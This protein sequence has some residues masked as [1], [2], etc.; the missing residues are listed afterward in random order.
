M[1]KRYLLIITML[2]LLVFFT[3]KIIFS[4]VSDKKIAV[5]PKDPGIEGATELPK[6]WYD[7]L[8]FKDKSFIFEFI[9]TMGYS[10]E[11]GADI[12]E[13]IDTAR[14]IKDGDDLSWYNEWLSTAERIFKFAQNMEKD[15]DPV[16]AKEAYLR[17]SNYYRT[18][19]FYMHSKSDLPKALL[20][21]KKSKDSF[22]KAVSLAKN[23]EI[24]NI[25]Y[26]DTLLPGYFIKTKNPTEKKPPLLIVHTGFDGTAEE[27]FFEVGSAA[28][29]RGYNCLVF[30][31][32]GQ[33]QVIREQ[34]ISFRYDWEKVVT[35]VIDY[36]ISRPDVDKEKLA[37]MGISMGG[38]L[39]PRAAAFE[40]RIKAC[41]ANGGIYDFSA[42]FYKNMPPE[43]I[44]LLKQDPGEFNAQMQ[45]AMKS[46][47]QTRW[48]FN[49]GMYTFNARSP[50]EFASE[51]TKY[52]LKDAVKKIKCDMLIIDSEDDMS[53]KG[54]AKKL[55]D[56]LNC[57][58]DYLL[59]T[60]SQT[61][62]AHCQMGAS[63]ISNEVIFNWLDKVFSDPFS[64]EVQARLEQAVEKNLAECQDIKNIPGAVVGIWVPGK[65]SW[66]KTFGVSDLA[67]GNK[68]GLNNKF[69]IGSNTKTFVVTVL[70]QLT[71]EGRASLDDT[72]DKFNF[73][74]NIPDENKI[75]IR[76]L[77]NMTSGIPEIGDNEE[78]CEIFYVKNPLKK[79]LPTEI[80]KSALVNKPT[81]PPGEG[82]YYS[83][84][85]YILLGM[86]IEKITGNKLEDEIRERI[87]KPMNLANT[88]FPVDYP[89][90]PS[91]YAHGYELD[92]NKKWQ[93]V[94]IYSPSMLWAAGAMISDAE[95]MKA[96]V[97][98]YTT[99]TTNSK[100]TQKER[101]IW[102]DTHKGKNLGFG[103][104]IGNTNGWLGYTGGT[105]GYNT[106]AYYLPSS[107]AT[108]IVFVNTTDYSKDGVSVANK[109]VH[110]I[111]QILFPDQVAW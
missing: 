91:P 106:A 61:A 42:T 108:V 78:M 5:T 70:L 49:N 41:I 110:D 33:G 43:I 96:W 51:I 105:R 103:L 98:A 38:Y 74:I 21:W 102:V 16:S 20:S 63:A 76:Q 48:Y 60:R 25:P 4:E 57:P 9:R 27:L 14:R 101:L 69:R 64:K 50:A 71:D 89:G 52:N 72:L 3:Q 109:I 15:A 53:L 80:V 35:P 104:G 12:G 62:Q 22:L 28:A 79:W 83:N 2:A 45:E 10:Y 32:P 65:G 39:A 19:G 17:A 46:S 93:D 40:H 107:D 100:A 90:M 34:K 66:E 55:Y 56:E 58:K 8:I 94:T 29:R 73:G 88:S 36:A 84:T 54:E 87:L 59:F 31:G 92:D 30:E 6:N 82:W 13:C 37:L 11:G 26:Q 95:D 18:A 81:F 99:G 47:T 7:D 75:T 86:V 97:K 24:I 68:M 44:E 111:T 1:L 85:G 77:C 23:I 67:T